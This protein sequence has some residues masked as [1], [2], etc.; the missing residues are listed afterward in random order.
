MSSVRT[1]DLRCASI[2]TVAALGLILAFMATSLGAFAAEKLEGRVV[3]TTLTQCDFKPRTCE[4][5]VDLQTKRNGKPE[6]VTIQVRKGTTIRKGNSAVLLPALN[7]SLVAIAYVMENGQ[8]LA[9]SI[10]VKP[11]RSVPST[12]PSSK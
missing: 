9:R 2:S 1:Q 12:P 3:T 11:E 5:S 10:E 8:K 4:G 6:Q 7:G